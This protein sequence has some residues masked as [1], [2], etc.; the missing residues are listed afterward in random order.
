MKKLLV[1]LWVLMFLRLL[2]DIIVIF[3]VKP[4]Y[5]R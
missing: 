5:D 4:I 1:A 2:N 3:V